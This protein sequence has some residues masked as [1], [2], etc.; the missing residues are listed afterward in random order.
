MNFLLLTIGSHGDVHPFIG[1]AR[2]LAARGHQVRVAANELYA[3]TVQKAGV[4]FIELGKSEDFY[5]WARNP[6]V[7]HPTRGSRV[8]FT[9][10]NETIRQVYDIVQ[11]EAQP[12]TRMVASSLCLG[13]RIAAERFG[14]D[15]TMA[16]LSPI[17]VRS[18]ERMP[19]VPGPLDLN[20]L[21]RS[22]RKIFW[23]AAD[24]FF[25]DPMLAPGVNELRRELQLPPVRS[26]VG[27]YW[28]SPK[29]TIGLWPEWFFPRQSDYPDC[30]KLTGFPLYDESEQASIDPE[31]D[32]WLSDGTPPIAFTPGSAM[33]FGQT[34]FA[35]AVEACQR[36][37]RRGI[38]LTR[39]AEQIPHDLPANVR[40]VPFIPFGQL[41]RRCSAVVHHG[42]I[43]STAQSLA[44]G[45]PQLIMPMSHDQFDNAGVCKTLG[46]GDSLGRRWFTPGRV[47]KKLQRLIGDPQVRASC[48]TIVQKAKA[49][50]GLKATCDLLER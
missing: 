38:L 4:G 46:V 49:T 24:R 22:M 35:T 13:A 25:V 39:H 30:V 15:L 31:L 8:V 40:H 50:D 6:D 19:R 42:G 16:H 1:L 7:W 29:L 37:N 17:C 44:T 34:F 14:L 2:A 27:S 32:H 5:R 47:A 10:I 18:V 26:I 36:L 21:P 11:R 33:L 43:G 45:C 28:H 9:A 23:S 20:W 12:G 48:V 41:L 3:S